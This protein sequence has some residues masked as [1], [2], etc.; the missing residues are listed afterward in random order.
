M[1]GKVHFASKNVGYLCNSGV[2]ARPSK[3]TCDPSKVTCKNCLTQLEL[4]K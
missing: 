2:H 4:L 3:L 1:A